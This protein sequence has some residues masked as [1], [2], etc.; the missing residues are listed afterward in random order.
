MLCI[1]IFLLFPIYF[2]FVVLVIL[3]ISLALA[4][5]SLCVCQCLLLAGLLRSHALYNPHLVIV[6][7][8]RS[9]TRLAERCQKFSYICTHTQSRGSHMHMYVHI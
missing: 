8:F 5:Y 7:A 9:H 4:L 3:S 2:S 1:L 6:V